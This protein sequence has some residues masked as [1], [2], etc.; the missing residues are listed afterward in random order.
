MLSIFLCA[1]WPP[2]DDISVII[3]SD[4]LQKYQFLLIKADSKNAYEIAKT[5]RISKKIIKIE[6]GGLI[7]SDF[8]TYIKLQQMRQYVLGIWIIKQMNGIEYQ[9]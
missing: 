1:C 7:H 2:V 4:F 8:K 9:I 6:V 5:P 3:P